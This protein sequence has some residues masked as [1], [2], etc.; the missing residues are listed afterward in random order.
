MNTEEYCGSRGHLLRSYCCS[1]VLQ[2][3]HVSRLENFIRHENFQS[4]H[5]DHVWDSQMI[6]IFDWKLSDVV[7]GW[8]CLY[9]RVHGS[10]I[11]NKK[12][13]VRWDFLFVKSLFYCERILKIWFM[14]L[15][16]RLQPCCDD[17]TQSMQELYSV[18]HDQACLQRNL[19]HIKKE[20]QET[21]WLLVRR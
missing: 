1:H 15:G 5:Q 14:H 10:C 19:M 3:I 9:I 8:A 21:T 18:W 16:E 11:T 7:K 6:L 12:A 13:G 17:L 2:P 20:I 4:V